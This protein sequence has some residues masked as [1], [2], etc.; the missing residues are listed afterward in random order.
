MLDLYHAILTRRSVRRYV[1]EPL[2]GQ[3]ITQVRA[4]VAASQPLCPSN[5]FE[6]QFHD[7]E[8]DEDLVDRLGGY[9]RIVTPPHYLAPYMMGDDHPLVDLGYRVEQIAVR[10][11]QLGIGTCYIGSLGRED[12]VRERFGL[13]GS[14]R[15]GAFLAYGYPAT[16]LVG[17]TF[18]TALRRIVG[19]TDKL[20]LERIFFHTSFDQPATP[21][22]ELADTMEAAR[23]APSAVNAQPWR[24]LWRDETLYLFLQRSNRRY[25][26]GPGS[27]YR[28]YDGGICM[29]NVALAL[30]AQGAQGQWQLFDPAPSELPDELPELEPLAR[31]LLA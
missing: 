1:Q 6:V 3:T 26:G 20:P 22:P 29:A 16:G 21:P 25:G 15:I 10:L 18:N 11:T 2:D 28:Y 19:A 27:D 23:C 17:R 5:R 9:G 12:E 7:V 13:P 31:L 4:I 8:E 24:F 30:E 14:A